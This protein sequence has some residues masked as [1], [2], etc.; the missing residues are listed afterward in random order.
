MSNYYQKAIIEVLERLSE[1]KLCFLYSL[2]MNLGFMEDA[3]HD[4]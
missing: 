2:I 3:K 1:K 4:S